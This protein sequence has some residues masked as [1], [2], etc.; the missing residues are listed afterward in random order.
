MVKNR[1]SSIENVRTGNHI[2]LDFFQLYKESL[3]IFLHS[4]EASLQS[5]LFC[6]WLCFNDIMIHHCIIDNIS[7]CDNH[8]N[9]VIKEFRLDCK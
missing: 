9:F 3:K 7:Y 5:N 4:R 2:F 1:F 8:L 6:L